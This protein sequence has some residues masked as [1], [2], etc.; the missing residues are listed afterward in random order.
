MA[1]FGGY[2]EYVEMKNRGQ[3]VR[4]KDNKADTL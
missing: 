2:G 4:N 1:K 3:G